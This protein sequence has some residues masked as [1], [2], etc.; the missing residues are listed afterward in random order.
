MLLCGDEYSITLDTVLILKTSKTT[1]N[2][3]KTAQNRN[4]KDTNIRIQKQICYGNY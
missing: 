1:K 4:E 3:D 2:R